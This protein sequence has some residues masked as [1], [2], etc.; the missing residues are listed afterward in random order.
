M[1]KATGNWHCGLD[2]N[3]SCSSDIFS[4]KYDKFEEEFDQALVLGKKL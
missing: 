2:K 1:F 4:S 3:C